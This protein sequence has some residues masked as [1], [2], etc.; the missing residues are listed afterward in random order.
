MASK[1]KPEESTH[2]HKSD[3]EKVHRTLTTPQAIAKRT[4]LF[5]AQQF[6]LS[7]NAPQANQ[8]RDLFC[9]IHKYLWI[10]DFDWEIVQID[11]VPRIFLR[12][13]SRLVAKP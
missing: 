9:D 5:H 4:C 10:S 2:L 7:P 13:L 8:H 3:L 1:D 12:G 6:L 11:K